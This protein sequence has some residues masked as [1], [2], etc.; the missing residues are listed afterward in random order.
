MIG[1]FLLRL[2]GVSAATPRQSCTAAFRCRVC[3]WPS[4]VALL[5]AALIALGGCS[6]TPSG[7]GPY[8]VS[9]DPESQYKDALLLANAEQKR[10]LI[11]FGANWCPDCRAFAKELGT[12]PL[13]RLISDNFVPLNVNIGN[14][15]ENMDFVARFGKPVAQ[16][17]P[18]IAV[19]DGDGKIR[20]VTQAGELA[21]VRQTSSQ[22]LFQWFAKLLAAL[23]KEQGKEPARS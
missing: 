11:I 12:D 14:W 20:F 10:V 3:S 7:K 2:S 22:D 8:D 1:S 17:I 23:D 16:G 21:S 15:D 9:A 13:Q 19:A 5:L 4:L 6:E 18:S